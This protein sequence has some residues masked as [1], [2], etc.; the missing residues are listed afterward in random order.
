[1]VAECVD[2][3]VTIEISRIKFHYDEERP[4]RMDVSA[5]EWISD[6]KAL[7]KDGSKIIRGRKKF[8]KKTIERMNEIGNSLI[9]GVKA[10]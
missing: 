9:M 4:T 5:E 7:N 6:S 2:N 8:R 10:D 3:L 1:M